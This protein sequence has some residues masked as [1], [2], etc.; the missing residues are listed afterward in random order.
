LRKVQDGNLFFSPFSISS[1]FGMVY[2]GAGSA[3]EDEISRVLHLSKDPDATHAAFKELLG[4][5]KVN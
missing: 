5:I 4:S 2:A 3:T 1:A